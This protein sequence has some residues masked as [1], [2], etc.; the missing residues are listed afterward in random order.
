[1]PAKKKEPEKPKAPEVKGFT[2]LEYEGM[3]MWQCDRCR[4]GWTTFNPE[5]AEEH[6][7][8]HEGEDEIAQTR[9]EVEA[10]LVNRAQVT[11]EEGADGAEG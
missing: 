11:T 10:D 1:M 8:T 4:A 9:A 3:D 6:A 7:K 5:A 2:V